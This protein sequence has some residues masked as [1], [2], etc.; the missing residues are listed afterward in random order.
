MAFKAHGGPCEKSPSPVPGEPWALCSPP[1]PGA[2][3]LCFSARCEFDKC[4]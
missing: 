1:L 3:A 2:L 4:L